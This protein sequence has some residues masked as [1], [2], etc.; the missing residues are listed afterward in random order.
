MQCCEKPLGYAPY[1]CYV[2]RRFHIAPTDTSQKGN[3]LLCELS[4]HHVCLARADEFSKKVT[5]LTYYELRNLPEPQKLHD[6]VRIDA[7]EAGAYDR[8]VLSSAFKNN[9]LVPASQFAQDSAQHLYTSVYGNTIE[10]ILFDEIP[11]YSLILVHALP[12]AYMDILKSSPA[13]AQHFFST[14]L[15]ADVV[16]ESN[17]RLTV[18]FTSNE[19]FVTA[20]K[21]NQL[22]LAQAYFYTAPLDVVYYLLSICNEYGFSQTETAVTLSG[23]ISEDSSL[24]KELHQYFLNLHFWK[25]GAAQILQSE[26]P[27]H[28]FS[29]I[30]NLAACVL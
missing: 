5:Q 29:S 27:D 11:A 6:I 24:Y 25:P 20:I 1:I 10:K 14:E 2:N 8:V 26:Y 13:D 28:F 9:L 23:L 16:S 18:H 7:T 17:E 22:K 21:N 3:V 30:H 4:Q 19:F 12:Q 15:K